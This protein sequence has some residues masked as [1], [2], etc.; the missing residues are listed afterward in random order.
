[1]DAVAQQTFSSLAHGAASP[2]AAT[3]APLFQWAP[4]FRRQDDVEIDTCGYIS[5]SNSFV[6]QH[7]PGGA[8]TTSDSYYGCDQW[9]FTTCHN[10]ADLICSTGTLGSLDVCCSNS[11][12][13]YCATVSKNIDDTWLTNYECWAAPISG[14]FLAL[15]QT[16]SI[17]SSEPTTTESTSTRAS[18][19]RSSS[20]G[21]SSTEASGEETSTSASNNGP[22]NDPANE[23]SSSNSSNDTNVGA[24]VGGVLG[25]VALIALIG[26]GFWYMRRR[27]GKHSG[28]AELNGDSVPHGKHQHYYGG[29]NNNT[30][31]VPMADYSPASRGAAELKHDSPAHLVEAPDDNYR[32]VEA[33]DDNFRRAELQ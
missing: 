22:T 12:W 8:C 32:R 15:D 27:N 18:S 31:Y 17:D 4:L 30:G 10:S 2:P 26:F 6:E 13:P 28:V 3:A 1:M 24:I 25:G 16:T 11:D 9:F 7:C 14:E 5:L 29:E 20:N 21:P 33:P 19:T 23:G